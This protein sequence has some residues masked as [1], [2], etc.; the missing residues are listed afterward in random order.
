MALAAEAVAVATAGDLVPLCF[1]LAEEATAATAVAAAAEAGETV[2]ATL[3]AASTATAASAD[4]VPLHF[5]LEVG[6]AAE[7]A[8]VA[9]ASAG[10]AT[11]A[12]M[13]GVLARLLLNLAAAVA[14]ADLATL[15]FLA[16][17]GAMVEV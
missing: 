14:A 15:P 10:A 17:R 1:F 4:L 11:A 12:A 2:A 16:L 7:A 5:L 9:V 3:A 13:V 8:A 6:A